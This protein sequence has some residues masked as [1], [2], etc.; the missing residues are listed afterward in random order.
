MGRR[1]WARGW[2]SYNGGNISLKIDEHTFLTTPTGVS[3]GFM[4]PDMIL[5][6]NENGEKVEVNDEWQTTSE[7]KLHA[8]CYK[9]RADIGAVIH[10]HAPMLTTFA[11]NREGLDGHMLVDSG[12][13]FGYIPCVT[14]H[15]LGT[16]E[17][18]DSITEYIAEHDAM[19]L[20][21]HGAL[22][23]GANVENA[24]YL[25]EDAEN[26]ANVTWRL[27]AMGA[28]GVEFSDE[29]F[30]GLMKVRKE[31]GIAGRHPGSK[32]A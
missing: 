26:L 4:T 2:A 6:V 29:E 17:L 24:Y 28:R 27:R 31:R 3:K 23:V 5:V 7:F 13:L 14:Y 21:N 1:I 19:I 12:V 8:M 16:Q 10:A 11:A 30:E 9:D 22:A 32:R 15:T 20:A 25:L 18:A